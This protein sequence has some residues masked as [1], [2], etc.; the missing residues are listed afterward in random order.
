MPKAVITSLDEVSEALQTEYEPIKQ[1]SPLAKR[2]PSMVGKFALKVEPVGGIAL[3]DVVGLKNTVAATRS[4]RDDYKAKLDELG[5][6]SP[7]EAKAALEAVKKGGGE[8]NIEAIKTQLSE[9]HKRELE[10]LQ[11][12][13]SKASSEMEQVVVGAELTRA[14]AAKGGKPRVIEP[15]ARQRVGVVRDGGKLKPVVFQEDG[16][17]PRLSNKTGNSSNMTIEE[18]VD[19]LSQ[20]PDFAHAFPGKGSAGVGAAGGRDRDA[21]GGQGQGQGQTQGGGGQGAVGG[22]ANGSA[23]DALREA[24]RR[25][26]GTT[27]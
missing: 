23:V 12:E 22:S 5:D 14:I 18:F 13:L 10:A 11:R 7:A 19:E 4:E 2:D 25:G 27:A 6:A 16:K 15:I 9:K 3:E 17:T 21:N 1:G 20:D 26:D 8:A 24:R